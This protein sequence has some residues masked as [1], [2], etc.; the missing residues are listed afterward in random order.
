MKDNEAKT[1]SRWGALFIVATMTL[2]T[3]L[4]GN[5]VNN[6]LP[7]L[8]I[9][10]KV[11]AAATTWIV[12]AY[13]IAISAA[14]VIYGRFGDIF[15]GIRVF[16]IGVIV[17]TIGS[18]LCGLSQS[19]SMLI[20][21]RVLQ[22]L[23]GAASMGTSQGII[24]QTF[25]PSERGRALGT[26]G[27]FVALGA[28]AGPSL[29]ALILRFLN[30]H[31]I[32]WINVPI[33]IA[34]FILGMKFLR[35]ERL[36][37]DKAPAF[38]MPGALLLSAAIILLTVTLN[39]VQIPVLSSVV[40][41]IFLLI[42]MTIAGAALL[43]LFIRRE[44]RVPEPL[45]DL[46]IFRSPLFS[47]SI[48]CSFLNFVT[49]NSYTIVYPYY[50][51]TQLQLP[52]IIAGLCLTVNPVIMAIL[53]PIS[54]HMSDRFGSFHISLIGLLV[55]GLAFALMATTGFTSPL[56]LVIS[57]VAILSVGGA[58]F[59]SP[60]TSLIMSSVPRDK[61]GVAGSVNALMR[62]LGM[63]VGSLVSTTILYT[64][65]NNAHGTRSMVVD[66]PDAA[67]IVGMRWAYITACIVCLF[68]AGLTVLR[69]RER[70]HRNE[71]HGV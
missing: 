17:F 6:A 38:D 19:F 40:A 39:L 3:S 51:Q 28:M 64:V 48:V 27:T 7:N 32:F 49:V 59:T 68:C 45:L 63:T 1:V 18:A 15:G 30:W 22:A 33:G 43:A 42:V 41:Q 67:F 9:S 25:P 13:L 50:L 58:L 35:N 65:I 4:D 44:L 71:V 21:A 24:T 31:V 54:G 56:W 55:N 8:E 23:G 29:G 34:V 37:T 60:N 26:N 46:K 20:V 10:L 52:E 66:K 12:T 5:I 61:V 14:I 53:A 57:F 11:T 47:I 69:M 2:M 70:S 36:R 62:N 16:R